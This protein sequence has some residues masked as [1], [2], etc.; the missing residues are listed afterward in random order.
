[1]SNSECILLASDTPSDRVGNRD[2]VHQLGLVATASY[3]PMHPGIQYDYRRA[4]PL[5]T[6]GCVR[7][8]ASKS[9]W[10]TPDI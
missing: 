5:S 1:M 10:A 4:V 9:Y 8:V 2:D 3:I 6:A 7:A